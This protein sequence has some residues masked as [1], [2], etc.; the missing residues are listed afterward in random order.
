M[1]NVSFQPSG[2]KIQVPSGLSLLDACRRAGFNIPSP[3]GGAGLCGQ[4]RVR[5]L[6]GRVPPE[7]AKTSCLSPELLAA[8]WLASCQINHYDD[9]VLADPKGGNEVILTEF[10]TREPR[11]GSG[12]WEKELTLPR[13]SAE[14]RRD[15][16]SRFCQA[17]GDSPVAGDA[18]AGR[19]PELAWL[20]R[21]PALLRQSDFR[22]RLVGWERGILSLL[23]PRNDG[24]GRRLGLAVDLG[25]T[26]MAA[27]LCDLSD[28]RVLGLAS[29][30]NPQSLRGDDVISRVEYAG[31]GAPELAELRRLALEAVEK[32]AVSTLSAAGLAGNILLVAVGGNTVMEHLLLGVPPEALALNP[33]IPAFLEPV[34]L[35]AGQLGWREGEPPVLI[36][37]PCVSAYVGGDIVA[38][39]LAH[40]VPALPGSTLFL[41]IGTNGEMAL[42]VEGRIYA[43]AAAAGPAFEGARIEQGMRASPGAVC[44]VGLA[45]DGALLAGLVDGAPAAGLCGT[46]LLDAVATMLRAGI[47]DEGGRMLERGEAERIN[48]PLHPD[49]LSRLERDSSGPRFWLERPAASSGGVA[50]S[51]KDVREFQLAKGAVAAGARAL[52]AEAGIE[53]EAVD[54]VLLAG[55]FGSY[56]NP[57]SALAVGLLPTGID[58]RR[59]SSVGNA[60]LAGTRLFLVSEA[61]RRAAEELAKRVEY[62]ELSGRD[63]FQAAFAEEMLFPSP[64]A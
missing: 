51:Q 11:S 31:R 57:A 9:L 43:C 12:I 53:P 15:D 61:E 33:F 46:G 27:A 50:L 2:V 60:A 64:P 35:G 22:C 36:T 41:D 3:C 10:L 19:G 23:N 55:G 62:V 24:G 5:L 1:P 45:E 28:G 48:P 6:S 4:C 52:L 39:L 8:G 44:R 21:M 16:W 13:P 58:L 56:L 40:D 14:D 7:S 42:A 47:V 49:L 38:G 59:V 34:S 37:L 54:R 29:L 25:T 18:W 20:A 63:S 17:L 30:A 26:T 32:L